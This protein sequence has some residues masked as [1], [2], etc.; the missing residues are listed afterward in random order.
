MSLETHE[1]ASYVRRADELDRGIADGSVFQ[2]QKMRQLGLGEFP[3]AFLDVLREDEFPPWR[4]RPCGRITG[5]HR[6]SSLGDQMA[7]KD[8]QPDRQ[9]IWSPL[10]GYSAV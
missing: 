1:G 3:D 8:R 9:S 7:S 10:A 5:E 4:Y 6:P 2:L